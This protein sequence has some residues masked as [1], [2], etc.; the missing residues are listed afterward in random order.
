MASKFVLK[1]S[2]DGFVFNL[3]AANGQVVLTSQRYRDKQSAQ[4]GIASVQRN[5]GSDERYEP[6]PSGTHFNL[7]ATNGEVI[8][9]SEIQPG[10]GP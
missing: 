7:K 2:G 6:G 4:A 9:S 5:A 3:Q 10:R 8:G 1:R